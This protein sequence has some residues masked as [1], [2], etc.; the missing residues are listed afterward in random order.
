MT[1]T[2]FMTGSNAFA[3]TGRD[4]TNTGGLK[5]QTQPLMGATRLASGKDA[6]IIYRVPFSTPTRDEA[7][8]K[9]AVYRVKSSISSLF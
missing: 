4:C 6:A 8:D 9:I 2:S 5:H 3:L 7:A 1:V